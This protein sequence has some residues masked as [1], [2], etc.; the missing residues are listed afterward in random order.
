LKTIIAYNEHEV[1]NDASLD[2]LGNGYNVWI[3]LEEPDHDELLG[4]AN[5]FNLDPDALETFFNKSKKPEIRLLDNHTFTVMLDMKNKDPKTLETEGIYFFLGRKWLITIHYPEVNLKELVERLFR[6][7]NK[8][9]KEAQIDG[10]YY[11]ILADIVTRYEQLLT[12]LELSVN[13]YQRRSFVRPTPQIFDSIETLSRK[14]IILRRHFWRVR[15]IINFL[16]HNEHDK[17]EI[18]Y[19]E[20]VYDDISQ[21]I[22]FVESY[23]GTINSIRELYVAKVSLQINDTMKLLTIFTVILLPLTL[24]AGIYGMNGLDLNNLDELP[25]GFIIIVIS[26]VCIGIG[27]LV[28]FIKKQWI[29]VREQNGSERVHN[30]KTSDHK[31]H[32][33]KDSHISYRVWNSGK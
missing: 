20:M 31:N 3:D 29:F 32:S 5:K 28:F 18:K 12:A 2:E 7:K 1:K 17:E 8:K 10:L 4:L 19:I 11:N 33:H 22:D 30:E 14:T 6:V 27:L 21:L 25:S 26:M 24:I 16:V 23:E 15:N 13:E 9:I